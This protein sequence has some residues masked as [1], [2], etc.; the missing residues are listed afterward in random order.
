MKRTD[1]EQGLQWAAALLR[2][3][4]GSLFLI[5]AINKL[6][7]G[8]SGT[9][10]FYTA[11]FKDSLLPQFLVTAH[12]SVI[13]FVEFILAFWLLS[14]F[15]LRAAWIASTLV[16]ISLAVGM[17]FAGKTDVASANYL[18]VFYSLIGIVLSHYDQWTLGRKA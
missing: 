18:Y 2:L 1:L 3:A 17:L 9:V 5:A 10:G 16:L 8:V 6:P 4:I 14:G 11:L 15:K 12:A 13:M 7:H